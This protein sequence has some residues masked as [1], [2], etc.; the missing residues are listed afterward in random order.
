MT[1][2]N[3]NR[4]RVKSSDPMEMQRRKQSGDQHILPEDEPKE[5]PHRPHRISREDM[6]KLRPADPDPDDPTSP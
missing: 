6:Q 2:T 5:D 1:T 3:P 4:D